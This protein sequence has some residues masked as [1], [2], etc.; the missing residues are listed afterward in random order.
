MAVTRVR[1]R[2]S[3]RATWL[4]LKELVKID[5]TISRSM[6]P[7]IRKRSTRR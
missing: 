3:M 4:M 2:S 1:D 6:I 7:M 5:T